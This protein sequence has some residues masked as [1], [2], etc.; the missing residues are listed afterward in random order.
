MPCGVLPRM[1]FQS[2]CHSPGVRFPSTSCV[3]GSRTSPLAS[4]TPTLTAMKWSGGVRAHVFVSWLNPFKEQKLTVVGSHGMVVFDDTRS[5]N[6]KLILHRH[7][8]TW[9]NGQIPTPSKSKGEAIGIPES[10]PLRNECVHFLECWR[11]RRK[12]RTD[13]M[14]GFGYCRSSKPPRKNWK[15]MVSRAPN[16]GLDR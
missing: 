3:L 9:T 16:L 2:S 6:E 8:L 14:E 12:P 13:G 15:R 11:D 7:Y 5:W 10:E 1:T 4:P